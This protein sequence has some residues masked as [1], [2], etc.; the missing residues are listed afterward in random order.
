MQKEKTKFVQHGTK[1]KGIHHE[2]PWGN[3]HRCHKLT[4]ASIIKE[5][6]HEKVN[7]AS[8]EDDDRR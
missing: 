7:V 4:S 8:I 2:V 6:S 1:S 5:E 3:Y